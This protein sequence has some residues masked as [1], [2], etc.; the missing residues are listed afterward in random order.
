MCQNHTSS[1]ILNT[2]VAAFRAAD[3]SVTTAT[4]EG[5]GWGYTSLIRFLSLVVLVW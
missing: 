5:I 3:V 4:A 1:Y 2:S